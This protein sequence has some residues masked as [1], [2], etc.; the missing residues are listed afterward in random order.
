MV[1]VDGRAP[2]EDIYKSYA[3][4][5]SRNAWLSLM[6]AET[7]QDICTSSPGLL[8]EETVVLHW[9]PS[10][11][12]PKRA[13]QRHKVV[14]VYYEAMGD[15]EK[16]LPEHNAHW[17]KFRTV[18]SQ[19][20][21]AIVCHTPRMCA[22]LAKEVAKPVS[23]LPVGWCP[24]LRPTV[25][26]RRP[27]LAYWGQRLGRRQWLAD[28]FERRMGA[29]FVDY[30]S[31]F[32]ADLQ[33]KLAGMQAALYL[34]HSA[35]WSFST[36]RAWQCAT[37]GTPLLAENAADAWPFVPG[38]HFI[39]LGV[40]SGANLHNAISLCISHLNSP[41]DLQLAQRF[42]EAEV[43]PEFTIDAVVNTYL[44]PLGEN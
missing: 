40:L 24:A 9:E 26:E 39:D 14:G 3:D 1:V 33:G 10:K 23:L 25:L 17:D 37:A 15:R 38:K 12:A 35:C 28:Q 41:D 20:L 18:W 29:Q 44:V 4:F 36:W 34:A 7:Y 2:F 27:Q 21:D 13:D 32:G 5:A 16:L 11:L 8:S 6:Q 30:T 42:V 31:C 19:A 22:A 43:L